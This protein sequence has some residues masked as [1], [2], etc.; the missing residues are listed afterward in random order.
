MGREFAFDEAAH[1]LPERLVF[2]CVERTC[3][4]RSFKH[5]DRSSPEMWMSGVLTHVTADARTSR[6]ASCGILNLARQFLHPSTRDAFAL[7]VQG[8]PDAARRS[9]HID[10]PQS[11]T[12]VENIEDQIAGVFIVLQLGSKASLVANIGD[13][14]QLA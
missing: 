6:R 7:G 11:N 1:D 12:A 14:P 13:M 2:G 3:R 10:V 8:L 9:W 4:T 5:G